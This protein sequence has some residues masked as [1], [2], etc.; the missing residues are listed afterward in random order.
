M[1]VMEMTLLGCYGYDD[2][3][4]FDEEE[5]CFNKTKRFGWVTVTK[6]GCK[7]VTHV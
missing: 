5:N 7:T 4:K 1:C 2:S 6:L 3:S